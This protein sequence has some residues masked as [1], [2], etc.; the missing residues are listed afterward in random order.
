VALLGYQPSPSS[1]Y[2]MRA[3]TVFL[4]WKGLTE[5][6]DEAEA[7]KRGFP[8]GAKFKLLKYDFTLLTEEESASGRARL[9]KSSLA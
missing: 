2:P 4:A 7:R 6:D 3:D 8:K 9:S 5:V 1:F